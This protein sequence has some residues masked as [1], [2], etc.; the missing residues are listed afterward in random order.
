MTVTTQLP[1]ADTRAGNAPVIRELIDRCGWTEKK[2]DNQRARALAK[3]VNE[4]IGKGAISAQTILR[5]LGVGILAGARVRGEFY[6]AVARTIGAKLQ[7]TVLPEELIDPNPPEPI[8][9]VV[10]RSADHPQYFRG[11]VHAEC[12]RR[13]REV[14]TGGGEKFHVCLHGAPGTGKTTCAQKIAV[15]LHGDFDWVWV[16]EL[17]GLSADDNYLTNIQK[18]IV[19]K[20]VDQ[21][22]ISPKT[23]E[24]LGDVFKRLISNQRLLFVLDGAREKALELVWGHKTRFIFTSWSLLTATEVEPIELGY[25]STPDEVVQGVEYLKDHGVVGDSRELAPFVEA[26]GGIFVALK[27]IARHLKEN[28]FGS[29]SA[30]LQALRSTLSGGSG[31]AA[32]DHP[33][34]LPDSLGAHA[35]AL[36]T[37]MAVFRPHYDG[38]RADPMSSHAADLWLKLA[39]FPSWFSPREA[40]D[41]LDLDL[42][43]VEQGLSRLVACGLVTRGRR[44]R[45]GAIRYLAP[46]RLLARRIA[47]HEHRELF[48]ESNR[49]FVAYA[50]ELLQIA[51]ADGVEAFDANKINILEGQAIAAN[52]HTADPALSES[53]VRFALAGWQ[54][55]RTRLPAGRRVAWFE[56]AEKLVSDGAADRRVDRECLRWHLADCYALDRRNL[57]RAADLL[58]GA[59]ADLSDAELRDSSWLVAKHRELAPRLDPTSA[60]LRLLLRS[61]SRLNQATC[62]AQYNPPAEVQTRLRDCL[63]V[64]VGVFPVVEGR[65]R[66]LLGKYL[67]MVGSVSDAGTEFDRAIKLFSRA[68]DVT[69]LQDA[70]VTQFYLV[71]PEGGR[72]ATLIEG[73]IQWR[74]FTPPDNWQSH[75]AIEGM[76]GS[77]YLR[78]AWAEAEQ[79]QGEDAQLSAAGAA[80]AFHQEQKIAANAED[81][82]GETRAR[83]HLAQ[84]EMFHNKVED[85]DRDFQQ[86]LQNVPHNSDQ[87]GQ[88]LWLWAEAAGQA[89]R[90]SVALT[91]AREALRLLPPGH[92]LRPRMDAAIKAW[93]RDRRG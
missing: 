39:V 49:Q 93:T 42:A 90:H 34:V 57:D 89:G 30:Y 50:V 66:T 19:Q 73:L 20:A 88:I 35:D 22:A 40:A 58:G 25:L 67:A 12:V 29:P 68:D 17:A 26:S 10:V 53:C 54:F 86:I 41:A 9:V 60:S 71:H 33:D 70:V 32:G 48:N 18:A 82:V 28:A 63:A 8:P 15:E 62:L 84:V 47:Y 69:G 83:A 36:R 31:W 24:P 11:V 16:V 46:A 5:M 3:E 76:L 85:A 92:W 52:H 61:V 74:N 6:K 38:L 43:A 75:M 55:V 80:E 56:L 79:G 23:K 4:L 1:D 27:H 87:S 81:L 78:Q 44:E 51:A 77:A 59:G 21:G 2:T 65:A 13:A 72:L 64:A 37:T 7:R 14:L 45:A 91:R